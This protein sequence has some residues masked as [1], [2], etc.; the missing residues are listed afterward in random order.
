AGQL[1]GAVLAA[2]TLY[3]LFHW[4]L[5]A[6]EARLG[7]TRGRPGSEVTAMCYG[8]YFPNP[9]FLTARLKE[10]K[11]RTPEDLGKMID[12][13]HERVSAPQAFLAEFLGTL[14]LAL[15]VF[16]LTDE[17]NAAAP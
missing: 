8:E 9:D 2:A 17:R 16:A 12:E 15:A 10:V 6:H 14:L 11:S 1:A 5:A 4:F 13:V 3:G 7:V